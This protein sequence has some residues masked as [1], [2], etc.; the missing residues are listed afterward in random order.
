MQPGRKADR[1]VQLM[2]SPGGQHM[3]S[4]NGAR[5]R[6]T[7]GLGFEDPL[8]LDRRPLQEQTGGAVQS[9]EAKVA[10]TRQLLGA[11]VRGEVQH[12]RKHREVVLAHGGRERDPE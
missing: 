2:R 3:P 10:L 4:V 1:L 7:P 6:V 12:T 9:S 11:H 5:C 8:S